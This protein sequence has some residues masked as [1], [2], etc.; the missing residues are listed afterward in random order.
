MARASAD[1]VLE[2]SERASRG[3]VDEQVGAA[4]SCSELNGDEMK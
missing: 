1:K 4:S 3:M 2:K